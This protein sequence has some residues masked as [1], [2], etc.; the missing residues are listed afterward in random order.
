MEKFLR[1]SSFQ[2]T[3]KKVKSLP[4]CLGVDFINILR[5]AYV[6]RSQSAKNAV[7]PIVFFA[8]LGSSH[9]KAGCKMLVKLTPKEREENRVLVTS[10][11]YIFLGRKTNLVL[12]LMLMLLLLSGK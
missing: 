9:V 12:L 11:V 5:A 2:L 4:T 3:E 7:K 8:L 1:D 6:R 10:F